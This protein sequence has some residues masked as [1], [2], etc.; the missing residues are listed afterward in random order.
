MQFI[1][2]WLHI[3][4]MILLWSGCELSLA[5]YIFKLIINI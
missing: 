2:V 5:L 3:S 1:S 4:G